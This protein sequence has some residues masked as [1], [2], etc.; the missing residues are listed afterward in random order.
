MEYQWCSF[1]KNSA[2]G[3]ATPAIVTT[4]CVF[5]ETEYW[6]IIGSKKKQ[7]L[8][9]VG[10]IVTLKWGQT[11]ELMSKLA[12]LWRRPWSKGQDHE[13]MLRG[14][15][16]YVQKLMTEGLILGLGWS[17]G[18]HKNWQ[19]QQTMKHEIWVPVIHECIHS[20]GYL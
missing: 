1:H 14:W 5:K 9:I 6:W 3:S 2:N 8:M 12:K 10:L 13:L 17:L 11:L 19:S 18:W 16:R 15:C 7:K 4:T 20:S